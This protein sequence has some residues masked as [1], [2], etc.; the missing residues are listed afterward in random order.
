MKR[1]FG[2]AIDDDDG[3]FGRKRQRPP[4][5]GVAK[6]QD[7][8]PESFRGTDFSAW[9]TGQLREFLDRRGYDYDDCVDRHDLLMRR[10]VRCEY[11]SGPAAAPAPGTAAA[12]DEDNG[13]DLD[14][15]MAEIK[16]AAT[17]DKAAA[18]LNQRAGGDKS[19]L[20]VDEDDGL[21]DFLDAREK[22]KLTSAIGKAATRQA[23]GKPPQE[24][25]ADS[26]VEYDASGNVVARKRDVEPLAP[27]D[28]TQIE[29][30]DFERGGGYTEHPEVAAMTDGDVGALR[31]R[32]EMRVAG[33]EVPR[34]VARFSQC[35]FTRDIMAAIERAVTLSAAS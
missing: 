27:V 17:R 13:E 31:R 32:M 22:G 33:E 12:E 2:G 10:A 19:A 29:Y 25:A 3:V 7:D 23:L 20:G 21:G 35:G 5:P 6:A 15:F 11:E 9:S 18:G 4:L 24:P 34:P 14:A 26:G 16:Q 30:P 1:A 8:V 28:H